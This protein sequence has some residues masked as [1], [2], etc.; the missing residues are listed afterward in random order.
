MRTL[1]TRTF[2]TLATLTL[3][4]A[5]SH[6]Q[7]PSA[8]KCGVETWSTDKMTYVS[9]P[10][11]DGQETSGPAARGAEPTLTGNAAYCAALVK[12]YDQ[13]LNR[14]SRFGAQ[15]ISLDTRAGAEKCRAGDPAGIG[16]LEKAL[17]DARI[18]LPKRS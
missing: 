2:V 6:A 9:T 7:S 10:C 16:A 11:A 4:A 1:A 8:A 14:D 5:A 12:K 18:D 17:R 15:P 13:Y 3:A